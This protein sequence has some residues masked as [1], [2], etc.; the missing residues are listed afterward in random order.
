MVR[1]WVVPG[2]SRS[3]L[4]GLHGS[5]L[6]VRV[7]APPEK[8]RANDEVAEVLAA[9]IGSKVTLIRGIRSREKVFEVSGA[10][11]DAVRRKLHIL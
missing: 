9:A 8:G 6:K 1:V 4:A 10:D 11:V 3:E 7:T 2:A 5:L